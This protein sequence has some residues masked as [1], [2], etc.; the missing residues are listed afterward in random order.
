MTRRIDE[1]VCAGAL[2]IGKVDFSIY[3][4]RLKTV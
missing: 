3:F 1:E 4:Q 2:E